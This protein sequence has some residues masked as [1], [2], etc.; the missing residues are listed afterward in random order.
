MWVNEGKPG[1][2]AKWGF[3]A[4][5]PADNLEVDVELEGVQAINNELTIGLGFLVHIVKIKH[6]QVFLWASCR[7]LFDAWSTE[8]THV[9]HQA[10][11]FGFNAFTAPSWLWHRMICI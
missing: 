2:S 6:S 9:T 3:V 5:S 7:M 10:L 11:C 8:V 4:H 1:Q